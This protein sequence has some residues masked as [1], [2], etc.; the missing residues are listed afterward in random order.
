MDLC[1]LICILSMVI[2]VPPSSENLAC[3]Y[4]TDVD[5]ISSACAEDPQMITTTECTFKSA[6]ACNCTTCMPPQKAHQNPDDF[7]DPNFYENAYDNPIIDM[8]NHDFDP[9]KSKGFRNK[10]KKHNLE[11]WQSGGNRFEFNCDLLYIFLVLLY[12]IY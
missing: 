11:F 4:C 6:K 10:T 2:K 12:L 9:F 7:V 5:G 1:E 3:S 8:N